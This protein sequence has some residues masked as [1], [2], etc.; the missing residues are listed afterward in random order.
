ME[1]VKSKI[2]DKIVHST[3]M[4][5]ISVQKNKNIA[6]VHISFRKMFYRKLYLTPP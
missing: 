3:E 5:D 4:A 2:I 6:S 1:Q